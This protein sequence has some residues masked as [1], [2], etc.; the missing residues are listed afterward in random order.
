MQMKP[1]VFRE[2]VNELRAVPNIGCK[3]ELIVGV[4]EKYG[5]FPEPVQSHKRVLLAVQEVNRD[6]FALMQGESGVLRA[7][8]HIKDVG[9]GWFFDGGTFIS[10]EQFAALDPAKYYVKESRHA[11]TG[12]PQEV[13]D[14]SSAG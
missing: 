11:S 3:R 10:P 5:I 8:C 4:L 7:Y 14:A 9:P 13:S 1:H 12:L 2:L 6:G